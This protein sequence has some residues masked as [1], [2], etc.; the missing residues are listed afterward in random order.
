MLPFFIDGEFYEDSK[1]A[2]LA[3]NMHAAQQGYAVVIKRSKS[4]K[5]GV[6]NKIILECDVAKPHRRG[7]VHPSK[8]SKTSS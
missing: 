1:T 2:I 8:S 3:I 5:K 4:D 7:G 6:K